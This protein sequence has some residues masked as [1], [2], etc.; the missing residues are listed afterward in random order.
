MYSLLSKPFIFIPLISPASSELLN[1][2]QPSLDVVFFFKL[3]NFFS[4]S[5]IA[6]FASLL[7]TS[8]FILK[9]A[10]LCINSAQF[11][12]QDPIFGFDIGYFV[13]QKP[14]DGGI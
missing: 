3:S 8:S 13:F 1:P 6:F 14:G 4:V 9:K 5:F 2:F 12:V 7:I 10:M 11:G